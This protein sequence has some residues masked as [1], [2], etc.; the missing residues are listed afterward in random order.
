MRGLTSSRTLLC[1]LLYFALILQTYHYVSGI[2]FYGEYLHWT[3]EQS[4]R[5][6][7]VAIIITPLRLLFPRADWVRWLLKHRRDIGIATFFYAAAHTIA[8]LLNQENIDN[9]VSSASTPEMLAGWV[10]FIVMLILAVTS[11]DLSVQVLGKRWKLLHR[12]VFFCA[13]LT[14]LHWVLTA[15]D[16]I[17]AY[18][19]LIVVIVLLAWRVRALSSQ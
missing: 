15:F 3:G 5:L 14:F 17:S 8:Y 2:S 12:T 11:N 19:H 16:P 9:I 10:A 7:I 6:L 13:A 18:L 4:V 1:A